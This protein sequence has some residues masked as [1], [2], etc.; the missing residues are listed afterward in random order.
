M[1]Y[2][3]A[4]DLLK[5]NGEYKETQLM[6]AVRANNI[7]KL[8]QLIKDASFYGVLKQM[9][10]IQD[11]DGQSPLWSASFYGY[12]NIVSMLLDAGADVNQ[13]SNYGATPL[14]VAS[15]QNHL[16]IVKEL[17]SRGADMNKST[18][19]GSSPAYIA[20]Y[21]GN[22]DVL[23]F[24]IAKGVDVGQKGFNEYSL[25]HVAASHNQHPTVEFL[26]KEPKIKELIDDSTNTFNDTP[27]TLAIQEDGDLEMIKLLIKNDANKDKAGYQNKTPLQWAIEKEKT[28]VVKYLQNL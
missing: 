12:T 10:N 19:K 21:K 1:L 27:L 4:S 24:L 28:D 11:I 16:P 7:A 23:T 17:L 5:Q 8:Q 13:L 26:L 22:I 25:L 6:D 9:V 2:L 14:Y 3:I 20:A 18:N 15:Q